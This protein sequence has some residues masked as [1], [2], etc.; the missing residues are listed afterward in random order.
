MAVE[1]P[2]R[3]P[4]RPKCH[5]E[6]CDLVQTLDVDQDLTRCDSTRKYSPHAGVSSSSARHASR[7]RRIDRAHSLL[8][9]VLTDEEMA[10]LE[11][12]KLGDKMALERLDIFSLK[13]VPRTTVVAVQKEH[14]ACL[15]RLR[16]A[17]NGRPLTNDLALKSRLYKGHRAAPTKV[18]ILSRDDVI[19]CGVCYNVYHLLDK[20]DK[21]DITS[22]SSLD[23]DD[24]AQVK[25]AA[26]KVKS[27]IGPRAMPHN[28][29]RKT[30][31][32]KELPRLTE[33]TKTWTRDKAIHRRKARKLQ[34]RSP[35]LPDM[36]TTDGVETH[37]ST[38][39]VD[40]LTS[41]PYVLL[42][43]R[44]QLSRAHS[45][46][47]IANLVVCHDIFDTQERMKILLLPI[48]ANYPEIQVL[49]WN[50]AG[51]AFSSFSA[52]SKLTNEYHAICLNQL[53][54]HVNEIDDGKR[55]TFDLDRPFFIMGFGIGGAVSTSFAEKFPQPNL[56]GLLL[57]NSLSF[58]DPHYASVLHDCCNVFGCSSETRPDLPFYFYSRFLFSRSYLARI[59]APLAFNIYTAVHNPISLRGRIQLCLGGLDSTD[60]RTLLR[61]IPVPIISIH[62]KEAGI[63]RPLHS[64]SYLEGRTSCD[65]IHEAM[66]GGYRTCIIAV[67]G[68]GHELFQERKKGI[69]HLIE[70]LLTGCHETNDCPC[71]LQ[72]ES[73]DSANHPKVSGHC[74]RSWTGETNYRDS[75]TA[76][77]IQIQNQQRDTIASHPENLNVND[78]QILVKYQ[79]RMIRSHGKTTSSNDCK[80]P[81]PALLL[82]PTN[83]AFERQNSIHYRTGGNNS[84]YPGPSNNYP[85]V[86]EYMSWRL[87]RNRKRLLRFDNATRVIQGAF[88]VAVARG[89]L[90][91]LR[92]ERVAM[93]I[94]RRFRGIKGRL[95]A[96]KHR[97]FLFATLLTQR[98][99]RG[100]LG[101]LRFDIRW[102][103]V[104]AQTL[105][106][107]RWRGIRSRIEYKTLIDRRIA[108]ATDMQS[109]WRRYDSIR[110]AEYHRVRRDA[111]TVLER[112]YRGYRGRKLAELEREQYR[113]SRSQSSGI[114]FGRQMLAEHK[115]NATRLRSELSLLDQEKA[116][117]EERVE[118]L[119]EEIR[120]CEDNVIGLEKEM[121]LINKA[122]RGKSALL[123]GK[124]K[125]T[126]R[127][128]K[129]R[130]DKD[131]GVTLAKIS[132]RKGE[133]KDLETKLSVLG[134]SIQLKKEEMHGLERNLVFL[135]EAQEKQIDAIRRKREE[136]HTEKKVLCDNVT[137]SEG[138]PPHSLAQR[139]IWGGGDYTAPTIRDKQEA[140][141]LMD[142]TEQMM[143]FGFMSMSMTYFSSLN[144]VRAMKKVGTHDAVMA[145]ST[146]TA[147]CGTSPDIPAGAKS[148]FIPPVRT[149]NVDDV[150][151]WLSIM[152]LGIYCDAFRE[153]AVDGNF[154][155]QLTDDD[156]QY[157]LG[158]EHKLHRKKI[159]FSISELL[160]DPV[161]GT[162]QTASH[163]PSPYA[164]PVKSAISHRATPFTSA[165]EKFNFAQ[166]ECRQSLQSRRSQS[167]ASL[168]QAI[169]TSSKS[170][171][172][173]APDSIELIR[174]Q[175]SIDLQERET[176]AAQPH[177]Q[178]ANVVPAFDELATWVRN[179]K[180]DML[181]DALEFLP[182][183][184]FDEDAVLVQFVAEVGTTY[185][186]RPGECSVSL[187]HRSDAHGNSLL[188]TAAQNGNLEVAR[189]LLEKGSN[190]NHQNRE[191]QTAGHFA[192]A[193]Q[194]YEFAT[195]LFDP[196]GGKANDLLTNMYGLGPYD[197]LRR[198]EADDLYALH[199]ES[200]SLG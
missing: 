46:R 25:T 61:N 136:K 32:E 102:R 20:L 93:I 59:S 56:R 123:K 17:E 97:R 147:V 15:Y 53:L 88:G 173:T 113:F 149:W 86:S 154:L 103:R 174:Q 135:L 144:M 114:E 4:Q 159:L 116:L 48:V 3:S 100:H 112:L 51:Q 38:F 54:R 23:P 156:L 34:S 152:S 148:P 13:T 168:P 43:S 82:D 137:N 30:V 41:I 106:S 183:E 21:V 45:R 151:K 160:D 36:K 87:K 193:Y 172:R 104:V 165:E 166:K 188:H 164:T 70:Q 142:S 69:I 76:C 187:L 101:R 192:L 196:S 153:G 170:P 146:P 115:M 90:E 2:S 163:P 24:K 94:Q 26:V 194:F 185:G 81:T 161:S 155:C 95:H 191:G 127:D 158:V 125:H 52:D 47:P 49:L 28:V 8:R 11:D 27:M 65:N 178:I 33:D 197:G 74:L 131:F 1:S 91:Y 109:L 35:Q 58:V 44:L 129:I 99:V 195:W 57:I 71:P 121:H 80:I 139:A 169:S 19:V 150:T 12:T 64:K 39:S 122:E 167:V 107:S 63:V 124:L 83:P 130:L 118:S 105:L 200:V 78:P 119:V 182:T 7:R 157:T 50:Y 175:T 141:D 55:K 179:Q 60:N 73:N 9:W 42:T 77:K 79:E 133:L 145:A 176:N 96:Q 143:K 5:G 14:R 10:R 31:R 40:E 89:K 67:K 62:G 177:P 98:L 140:A 6:F 22:N 84:N 108:A 190:P 72:V 111:S 181:R 110:T 132:E 75:L 16:L 66:K 184:F 120:C 18:P 180:L 138:S 134:K 117:V 171:R 85:E 29:L 199:S 126:L 37:T 92:R 162:Q 68:G 189:L 198:K 128:Q 186:I